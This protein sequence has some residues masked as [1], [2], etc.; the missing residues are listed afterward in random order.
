VRCA[1][2]DPGTD[3][4]WQLADVTGTV[5][6]ALS[7]TTL[8]RSAG[9][10]ALNSRALYNAISDHTGFVAN[11]TR[12]LRHAG[13]GLRT[14]AKGGFVG[15][16]ARARAALLPGGGGAGSDEE[17]EDPELGRRGGALN[18]CQFVRLAVGPSGQMGGSSAKA[19]TAA[20]AAE[21]FSD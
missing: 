20:L 19:R 12:A 11:G 13:C 18:A 5:R 14:R 2:C 15:L 16:S 10:C 7:D 21:E 3:L 4:G 8:F 17:E 6:Q 9:K 1:L